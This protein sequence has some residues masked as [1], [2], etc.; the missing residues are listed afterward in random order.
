MGVALACRE[1]GR[2]VAL[3]ERA[4]L[5]GGTSSQSLRVIHGGFRY[6]QQGNVARVV[7]SIRARE[8]LLRRFPE[9][10]VPLHCQLVLTGWKRWLAPAATLIFSLLL[11]LLGARGGE[12]RIRADGTLEWWDGFVPDH[13]RLVERLRGELKTAGVQIFENTSVWRR[14]ITASGV[15]LECEDGRLLTG[16]MVVVCSNEGTELHGRWIRGVNV[17]FR[18]LLPVGEGR[19]AQTSAGRYL[20]AVGRPEGKVA[21]GTW[22]LDGELSQEIQQK[23][24]EEIESSSLQTLIQGAPLHFEVGSLPGV[25]QGAPTPLTGRARIRSLSREVLVVATKYT[26]FLETGRRVARLVAQRGE[27]V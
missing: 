3:V 27:E 24:L 5:G 19:G 9:A 8:E 21:V 23:L 12:A 4:T 1:M 13:E 2:R 18:G 25:G 14:E 17:L 16:D 20:F 6:L 10:V 26:T 7:E 11:R 22:Y 15:R